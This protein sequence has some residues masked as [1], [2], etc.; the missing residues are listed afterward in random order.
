MASLRIGKVRRAA[1]GFYHNSDAATM[2]TGRQSSN[3]SKGRTM[4][5]SVG[6]SSAIDQWIARDA[7][8][9]SLDSPA[10]F[11]SAVDTLVA[12]LG[13]KI[14]LLGFGEAIHGGHDILVLRN[15]L[16]QRLVETHGYR[17]IAIES[18]FTRARAVNEYI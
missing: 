8:R 2:F 12:A 11:N 15:R 9:F 18:S 3:G 7:I 6:G 1:A 16:F 10:K 5:S 17:S 13:D 4:A 14:E